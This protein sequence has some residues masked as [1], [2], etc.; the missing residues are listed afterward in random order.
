M[1]RI[2]ILT[3]GGDT[4]G[5]EEP[6]VAEFAIAPLNRASNPP[7]IPAGL[8]SELLQRRP[9]LAAAEQALVA[10]NAR[11]GVAKAASIPRFA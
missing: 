2:G 3:E 11:I 9:D 1:K 5:T 6:P 10:A 4:L 7:L 8:P